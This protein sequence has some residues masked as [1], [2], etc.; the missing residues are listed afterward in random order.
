MRRTPDLKPKHRA[1]YTEEHSELCERT[2]VTLMRGLGPW[3]ESVFLIGGLVPRY[4]IQPRAGQGVAPYVGTMDVDL[5]LDLDVLA[6]VDAYRRLEQNLQRLG[7]NRSTNDDGNA[8]HFRWLMTIDDRITI[9]VDLLCDDVSGISSRVVPLPGERRLSAL[10]LPGAYLVA[11]DYVEIALTADL[12]D[13]RGVATEV[14]RIANIVPFLIMKSL[15]YDERFEEKD[16]HDLIYCLS[17]YKRGPVDVAADFVDRLNRW[18]E[19]DLLRRTLQIL[20][21]RFASDGQTSGIEKD[22]PVSY[23]RFQMELG[24]RDLDE[25]HRRDAATVVGLFLGEVDRANANMAQP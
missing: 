1:A 12:L 20:R 10:A 2:L 15:A 6:G 18:E 11:E 9:A 3:K 14:V 16:A 17:H 4:L 22:G 24:R 5:V 21:D 8:Q 13:E 19:T 7:F 23:A 25:R